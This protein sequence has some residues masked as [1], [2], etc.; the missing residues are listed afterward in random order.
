MR[1][2]VESSW[3]TYKKENA[4]YSWKPKRGIFGMQFI[5]G[6]SNKQRVVFLD[7]VKT[8]YTCELKKHTSYLISVAEPGKIPEKDKIAGYAPVVVFF[9]LSALLMGK[10]YKIH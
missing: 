8:E 6:F 4:L 3:M 9:Q 7:V 2:F 5:F 10:Q 1:C